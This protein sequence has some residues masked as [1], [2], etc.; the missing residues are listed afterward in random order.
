MTTDATDFTAVDFTAPDFSA[1][2]ASRRSTRAFTDQEV[3]AGTLE[4]ILADAATAP[5]WSNTRAFRLA[6]A[7]GERADRLR[8]EYVRRFDQTLD[9]QHRKPFA[10]A[11]TA[12]RRELPDGDF[13]VWKPYPRELRPAQVEIAKCVYGAYGIERS[14]HEGRDAANRR[15]V[16]AFDAPVMGFVFVHQK[17][18]PWSAMDAGLMLQT[19]FLSA[20]AHGVDSCAIGILS[21]WRG[22]V[23][24]EFEIPKHYKLITG[25]ALGY[26]DTEVPI[27]QVNAPR[28]PIQ[29]LEGK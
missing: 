6:L 29:L 26:A 10:L 7:T 5:S 25:F 21:T 8:K 16:T 11:K 19:L 14:D 12:L 22:P 9:I 27:N 17:M 24:A 15:N 3:T 23:A 20:K 28:P 13:P 2:A 4:A 18:L 1:L